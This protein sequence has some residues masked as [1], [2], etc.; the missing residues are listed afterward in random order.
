METVGGSQCKGG[1]TM[2]TDCEM[3]LVALTH[4]I[5]VNTLLGRARRD[6][7]R[8]MKTVLGLGYE[9]QIDPLRKAVSVHRK[10]C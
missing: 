2:E 4:Q 8:L 5:Y 1:K 10:T 3:N 6:S 7:A 9:I